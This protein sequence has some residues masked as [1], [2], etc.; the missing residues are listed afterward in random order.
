MKNEER[1]CLKFMGYI[2]L[3][4]TDDG[5]KSLRHYAA[6]QMGRLRLYDEQNKPKKGKMK[7]FDNVGQMLDTIM[8]EYKI[9]ALKRTK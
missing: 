2:Y 4:K 9:R 7:A 6:K 8:R 3:P 5:N 1:R